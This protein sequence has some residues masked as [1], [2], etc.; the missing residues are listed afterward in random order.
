MQFI[1]LPN[2]YTIPTSVADWS[3]EYLSMEA[4]LIDNSS[5]VWAVTNNSD[6]CRFI[7]HVFCKK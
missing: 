2:A 6:N 5:T 3:V 4:L 7:Q 1:I